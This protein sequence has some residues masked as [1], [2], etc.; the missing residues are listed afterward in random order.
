[1]S[2]TAET[3][4]LGTVNKEKCKVIFLGISLGLQQFV[5]ASKK[6]WLNKCSICDALGDLVPMVQSRNVPYL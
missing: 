2:D 6:D 1:M 5:F 3:Q 4:S